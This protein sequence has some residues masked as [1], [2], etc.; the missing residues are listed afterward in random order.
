MDDRRRS[1]FS[2][3]ATF[4]RV[5]RRGHRTTAVVGGHRVGPVQRFFS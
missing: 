1:S 5:E 2:A 3:M 4:W